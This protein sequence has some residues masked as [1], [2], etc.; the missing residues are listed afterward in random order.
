MADGVEA[1]RAVGGGHETVRVP[2]PAVVS[3]EYGVNEPRFPDFKRKRWA[4][5]EW[6]LTV[7]DSEDLELPEE[8]LGLDG[9]LTEVVELE[10]VE[11]PDRLGEW[12]EGSAEEQAFELADVI[13]AELD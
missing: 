3:V 9:S 6:E 13:K 2:T 8:V 5:K 7:W 12:V 11:T 4:S 10:S 1:T